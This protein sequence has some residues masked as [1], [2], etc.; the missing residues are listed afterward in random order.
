MKVIS[1]IYTNCKFNVGD[2]LYRAARSMKNYFFVTDYDDIK[3]G[4]F[5]VSPMYDTNIQVVSVLLQK[6]TVNGAT[7]SFDGIALKHLQIK[8]LNGKEFNINNVKTE[9]KME[10]KSMFDGMFE[11]FKAQFIPQEEAGLR[12]AS[13]FSIVVPN[14]DGTYTGVKTDGTLISYPELV[15][16]DIPVISLL[17]PFN[18]VQK[19][20][21][22]KVKNTY[23]LVLEVKDDKTLKVLSYSG[24][25]ATKKPITDFIMQTNLVRVV[26]NY[27]RLSGGN[28]G[29]NPMM[30]A[31]MNSKEHEGE[32]GNMEGFM[33][34]MMMQQQMLMQQK[35]QTQQ[36]A[37]GMM[38][39][40][41]G[42]NPMMLAFMA[43]KKD[44]GINMKDML[45]YS[46]F[47]GGFPGM[48]MMNPA[49]QVNPAPAQADNNPADAED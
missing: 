45:M 9:N 30:L 33:F 1:V 16:L 5:I 43:D 21:I 4:D 3:A 18:S 32:S 37:S 41:A 22:I 17:K 29:M 8:K 24:Y 34:A 14:N 20:D 11:S 26:L 23:S 47:C 6:P 27:G 42:M 40:F 44:G 35:G 46:M 7:V 31:F 12:V 38:N 15:T 39:P 13:D 10:K 28:P 2:S 49:A 48:Q 36:Q 25:V 19:G